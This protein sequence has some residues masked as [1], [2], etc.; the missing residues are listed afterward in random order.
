MNRQFSILNVYVVIFEFLI[1][2]IG[3]S[4]WCLDVYLYT[5]RF[6]GHF[7][8]GNFICRRLADYQCGP[9]LQ[10]TTL[11]REEEEAG[12][13]VLNLRS[14]SPMGIFYLKWRYSAMH[15]QSLQWTKE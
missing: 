1:F 12:E 5:W 7:R 10:V 14:V 8:F 9:Y 6:W 4:V 11:H 15:N 2:L 3:P 13:D